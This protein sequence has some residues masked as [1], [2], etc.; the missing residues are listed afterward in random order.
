MTVPTVAGGLEAWRGVAAA[1]DIVSVDDAGAATLIRRGARGWQLRSAAPAAV[2]AEARRLAGGDPAPPTGARDDRAAPRPEH[3]F[4][5]GPD[6]GWRLGRWA[7]AGDLVAA[8]RGVPAD[9]VPVAACAHRP[10]PWAAA[11][12]DLA[13][14]VVHQPV[15]VLGRWLVVGPVVRNR[16][17]HGWLWSVLG[18]LDPHLA[19]R[20]DGD[21]RLVHPAGRA[22]AAAV[23][24]AV[25]AAREVDPDG[26]DVHLRD[27]RTGSRQRV[28]PPRSVRQAGAAAGVDGPVFQPWVDLEET[29]AAIPLAVAFGAATDPVRPVRS[30]AVSPL[31]G[32]ATARAALE[33]AE[34][35]AL[36]RRPART[37]TCAREDLPAGQPVVVPQPF[38]DG[39][40][41][42]ADFPYPAVDPR[43]PRPWT[44]ATS[45]VDGRSCWVPTEVACL[46][47]AVAGDRPCAPR[48]STGT[49]AHTSALLAEQGGLLEV[50]ERDLV[51]RHWPAGRL[52]RLEPGVWA[53]E[54][55]QV[56]RQLGRDPH[57]YLCA[58]PL[59]PVCVV[60]L[61]DPDTG[62][63]HVGGCAAAPTVAEA[64]A[65]A[66]EEALMLHH[67]GVPAD[68]PAPLAAPVAADPLDRAGVAAFE[69]DFHFDRLR[70]H[71]RAV[72]VD[73]DTPG[74]R[75]EG[76]V[77]RKVV[78]PVA[79]DLPIPGGPL[80][81]RL[82]D[83]AAVRG[84]GLLRLFQTG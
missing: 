12:A 72:S 51:V 58:D 30:A 34:R 60:T 24:S 14:A 2:L 48:T 28:R 35:F 10:R 32:L 6:E 39:Q 56:A 25:V 52:H 16:T 9:A 83:P 42:A 26:V 54:L 47:P 40:R 61:H 75:A 50:A 38:T 84:A 62:A 79:A 1:C 19:G 36:N 33:A 80:P 77:V 43:A 23:V 15:L 31:A 81:E 44:P 68:A 37:S 78:S 8:C 27:L 22:P 69:A 76:I 18:Q 29:D 74:L 57:L 53:R 71:Y 13:G 17:D 67:R 7:A 4:L 45:L 73:L 82:L 55:D 11:L 3:I 20:V 66:F 46:V 5:D 21:H 70:R 49:A 65:H 59:V 63:A 41:A 64:A